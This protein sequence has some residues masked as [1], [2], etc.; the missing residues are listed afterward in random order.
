MAFP[1]VTVRAIIFNCLDK[2]SLAESLIVCKQCRKDCKDGP[3]IKNE[4]ITVFELKPCNYGNDTLRTHRFFQNM[5]LRIKA[6]NNKNGNGSTTYRRLQ[7]YQHMRI[8]DIH[9]FCH[10]YID[11]ISMKNM[12]RDLQFNG[13]VSLDISFR[14]FTTNSKAS[15]VSILHTALYYYCISCQICASRR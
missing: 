14:I 4:V 10:D 9:R 7:H 12:A 2:Q 3:G 1:P 6:P 11:A 15:I 5:F 8:V 13:V